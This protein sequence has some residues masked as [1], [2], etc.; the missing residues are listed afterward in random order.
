V[1]LDLTPAQISQEGFM[2]H[3]GDVSIQESTQNIA[4]STDAD[5]TTFTPFLLEPVR[6]AFARG[7]AR[8]LPGSSGWTA[9]IGLTFVILLFLLILFSLFVSY[10]HWQI[11]VQVENTGTAHPAK[12]VAR[13]YASTEDGTSYSVTFEFEIPLLDNKAQ[14]FRIRQPVNDATYERLPEGS[15]V[16]VKYLSDD[17]AT[18]QLAGPDYNPPD[19]RTPILFVPIL[20]V[21]CSIIGFAAI[22]K[23]REDRAMGHPGKVVRGVLTFSQL[24]NDEDGS[25]LSVK[26]EFVSPLT[27][28]KISGKQFK[29][30]FH[31]DK[32]QLLPSPAP[33]VP[34][35]VLYWNES[36]YMM[37]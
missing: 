35:A 11:A 31:S 10:H 18:A 24:H 20:I 13:D 30:N 6:L 26:Y 17:P 23:I 16:T 3:P 9:I 36:H 14:V 8:H 2:A 21:Y 27:G 33:G 25:V 28:L 15:D 37:L 22:R 4:Q 19:I 1:A 5:D 29:N 12:I 32:A 7:A 34:V